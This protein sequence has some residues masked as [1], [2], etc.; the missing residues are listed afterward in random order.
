VLSKKII[1][2]YSSVCFAGSPAK[3]TEYFIFKTIF[4]KK[5]YVKKH[6]EIQ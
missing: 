1:A 2:T 5:Q 6:Q 3:Q 4:S